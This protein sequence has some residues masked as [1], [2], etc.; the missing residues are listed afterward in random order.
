[1]R[2]LDKTDQPSRGYGFIDFKDHASALAALRWT[3]NNP[4]LSNEAAAGGAAA[5]ARKSPMNEWP[6]LIVEFAV[7]NRSKI[8]VQEKR[9]ETSDKRAKQRERLLAAAAGDE[10]DDEGGDAQHN[11]SEGGGGE[12]K[13]SR[14]MRQRERKRQEREASQHNESG[15][16]STSQ[17]TTGQNAKVD[18]EAKKQRISNNPFAAAA[19]QPLDAKSR[20]TTGEASWTGGAAKKARGMKNQAAAVA[21]EDATLE[22]DALPIG[23][24]KKASKKRKGTKNGPMT[25]EF[26]AQVKNYKAALFGKGSIDA[27]NDDDDGNGGITAKKAAAKFQESAARWFE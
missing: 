24:K 13:M 26:D 4:A 2:D 25:D 21:P 6:R 14:G 12:K 27:A 17:Q 1:M 10:D 15:A 18:R 16:P 11:A 23:E 22:I 20:A 9:R 19:A 8:Q 3:N 5:V 7:E